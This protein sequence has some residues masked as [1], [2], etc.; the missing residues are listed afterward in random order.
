M[1]DLNRRMKNKKK[2]VH[3]PI[4]SL[5]SGWKFMSPFSDG[6]QGSNEKD[7]NQRFQL[8]L[9]DNSDLG[10]QRLFKSNLFSKIHQKYQV[11]QIKKNSQG[12]P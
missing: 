12:K 6:T 9:K 7:K 8:I 4:A 5:F 2:V 3:T 10:I 11:L 1:E